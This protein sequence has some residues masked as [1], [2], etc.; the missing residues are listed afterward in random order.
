M[1]V[2]E[3]IWHLLSRKLAGEATREEHRELQRLIREN[4]DLHYF[5]KILSQRWSRQDHPDKEEIESVYARH[6]QRM[7]HSRKTLEKRRIFFP[8][9]G[10]FTNYFKI[11]W[12]NILRYKSFSFVNIG[13]LAIGMAS[14]IL[15]LLW[16]QN[17][18]SYDQFHAKKD[19]IYLLEN[20]GKYRGAVD[21]FSG[22]PQPL[23]PVLKANYPQVE[24]VA[25]LNGTAPFTLTVG[26]KHFE[27]KEGI[28]T[29]PAFLKIFSF[30][31]AK[32]NVET[33]LSTPRSMVITESFAKRFFGTGDAM[34]KLIRIDSNNFTVT[35]VAKDPPRNTDLHFEYLIPYSYMKDAGWYNSSWKDFSAMTFVLLKPGVTEQM[36]DDRFRDIL[37]A[38]A[39]GIDNEV[40]LHPLSKWNLYSRFENGK[41]AGGGIEKVHL[42]GFLAAFIL[43][44]A[45]INYMNLSTAQSIRRAREV[46]IRKVVGAMRA[47][48]VGRFLGESILI[49]FL[50]GILGLIIVQLS[51]EGFNW[52][53]SDNLVVPYGDPYFWLDI[54]VFIVLTGVIAGSYPA[55]YLSG[56]RPITVLKGSFP[57]AYHLFSVRKILVVF[58]FSFAI[59][60]IICTIVIY[61]QINYGRVRDPGYNRDHLAFAYVKGDMNLKYSLIK[62]ELLA[63]G[64]A[65][66][67]TRSNSPITYSWTADDSYSWPGKDPNL[68]MPIEEYHADNDFLETTGIRLIAGRTINTLLYPTDTTAIL[69]NQSAVK[70]M[71]FKNPIGQI[72]TSK[73][74]NWTVIGVIRDFV[75]ESPF[76]NLSP[77]IIQGPRNWFGAITFR[78]N[79]RYTMADD[80]QKIEAIFRKYNPDY[81]F[82]YRFVTDA[83]NEKFEDQRR[84]A[85]QSAL[86]GGMAILISCLGLFAL[87]VYTAES[88]TKEIGV[89]KVL[90][91]SVAN[92]AT[93]LSAN[94]LKLVGISF[95]IASPLAW[96]TM[97]SWLGNFPYHI[98][99]GWLV[100]AIT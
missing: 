68:R 12:R 61:R 47:S 85:I 77:A 63:S 64:A 55:F 99:I 66:A 52:L 22:M 57:K 42:F 34:G 83:D 3:H 74:G 98:R 79:P 25:R 48:I 88:R 100:F 80:M 18:F 62:N 59:V 40:F 39:S 7:A 91:A 30:P 94:F 45:C 15:I 65:T 69:L 89:R 53:T 44:I 46:G 38:H 31:L 81:P 76:N 8:N 20:R 50:S 90:G 87:A 72:V 84:T 37:K 86:F 11:S 96:W 71:G 16:I 23:A 43:F 5:I 24:E 41:I 19:R 32:G 58:Q 60:F 95:G 28:M 82:I 75:L 29:D 35:G 14:A 92:I 73:Q 9:N 21:V 1:S 27:D 78:L 54:A 6:L 17:E 51:I 2:P 36:A 97:H 67:V 26:D 13:G 70:L 4:P 93:L 56:F 49:S 10:M 33:A